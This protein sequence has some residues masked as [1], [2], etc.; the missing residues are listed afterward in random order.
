[1]GHTSGMTAPKRLRIPRESDCAARGRRWIE[2]QA[3]GQL[4][5]ST[6]NNVKL[7]ATE[8]L[9][10]A[11]LHGHGRIE[12]LLER[13]GDRVLVEVVDDGEGAA[14]KIKKNSSAD[15]SGWGLRIVDQLSMS[16]GAHEGTTHIW[17]E[18]P[19]SE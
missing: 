16:W 13:R 8:L 2:Q 17:A 3:E 11:Y 5:E 6:L 19:I 4:N 18:L 10:N 12:L 9:N 14:V 7:V 1:M 15:R